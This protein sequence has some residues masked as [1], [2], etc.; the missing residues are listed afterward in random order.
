MN[1]IVIL[2]NG[3]FPTEP[4]PLY[5]LE[6]AEG[7]V[8]CDGAL[9]QWLAHNPAAQ[10]LAVVGDLGIFACDVLLHCKSANYKCQKCVN[11]FFCLLTAF[12]F[13]FA[14]RNFN[15]KVK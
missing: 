10:P 5:L 12:I 4:Y 11:C 1:S 14:A 8:C 15:T 3:Q 13:T 9:E 7:V 2:C 6:S